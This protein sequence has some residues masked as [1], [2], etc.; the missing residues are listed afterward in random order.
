MI[1]TILAGTAVRYSI[2]AA[3]ITA[4]M[5]F[6]EVCRAVSAVPIRIYRRSS[7]TASP[8]NDSASIGIGP[9]IVLLGTAGTDADD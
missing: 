5:V 3:R 4:E 2:H 8:A 9:W 7:T 6:L 1:R